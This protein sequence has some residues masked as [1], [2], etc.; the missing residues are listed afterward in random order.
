[1]YAGEWRAVNLKVV[2]KQ[3]MWAYTNLQDVQ[4]TAADAVR[5]RAVDWRARADRLAQGDYAVNEAPPQ[6]EAPPPRTRKPKRCERVGVKLEDSN[7]HLASA[8]IRAYA[9]TRS[10]VK[11][12]AMVGISNS[13]VLQ[14]VRRNPDEFA[15]VN[16]ELAVIAQEGAR[17]AFR[18]AVDPER[19]E[20]C[21]SPQA[22]V[23]AGI[24]AQ[25]SLELQGAMPVGGVCIEDLRKAVALHDLL[26]DAI[27][28]RGLDNA[29]GI[30]DVTKETHEASSAQ[31]SGN[32]PQ[33]SEKDESPAI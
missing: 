24:C 15:R 31:E 28:K 19:L 21:S 9:E 13:T 7:P 30:I 29:A 25:R 3:E 20:Q 26:S 6:L 16:N 14:V 12:G 8:A 4:E 27:K 2:D 33:P 11:A 22:A 10:G 5:V 17:A 23:V 32:E 18:I 1:M